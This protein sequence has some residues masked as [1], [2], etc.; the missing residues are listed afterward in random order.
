M[1]KFQGEIHLSEDILTSNMLTKMVT[2]C[3][4]YNI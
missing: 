2:L 4:T 1:N 3:I